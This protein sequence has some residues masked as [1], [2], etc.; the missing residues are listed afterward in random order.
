MYGDNQGVIA[1]VRNP[2]LHERSKHI[3]ISYHY[4]RDLASKRR[5]EITYILT[6]DMV[7]DGSTKPLARVAYERFKE[8]L[9][10]SDTL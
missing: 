7:A 6:Q 5:L 3:D 10:I 9:N 4:I 2:Q 1:L 8:Q